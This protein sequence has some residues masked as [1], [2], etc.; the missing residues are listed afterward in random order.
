MRIISL[1]VSASATTATVQNMYKLPECVLSMVCLISLLQ[2]TIIMSEYNEF[3]FNSINRA[4]GMPI[5]NTD[6]SSSVNNL[7]WM[8]TNSYGQNMHMVRIL[9]CFLNEYLNM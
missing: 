1:E 4:F 2:F 5:S 6:N 9:E 8:A 7:S 3:D